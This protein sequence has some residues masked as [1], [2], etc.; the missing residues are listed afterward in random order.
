[1]EFN[2]NIDDIIPYEIT[3]YDYNLNVINELSAF[4]EYD[5]PVLTR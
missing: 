1:M 5:R 3:V 2:F 4:E